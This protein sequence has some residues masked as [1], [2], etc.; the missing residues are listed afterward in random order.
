M[1]KVYKNI[2]IDEAIYNKM[3]KLGIQEN[4]TF[5]NMNEILLIEAL[6]A[7]DKKKKV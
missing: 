2:S 6:S 3:T 7:R 4:R 5:S 1:S